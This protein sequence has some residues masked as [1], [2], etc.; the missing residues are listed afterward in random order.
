MF[1]ATAPPQLPKPRQSYMSGRMYC[2]MLSCVAQAISATGMVL[3][4]SA[5]RN[6]EANMPNTSASDGRSHDGWRKARSAASA[7]TKV[8]TLEFRPTPDAASTKRVDGLWPPATRQA[9]KSSPGLYCAALAAT[10][11]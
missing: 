8:N 1:V 7:A 10:N 4:I 6:D 11:A 5:L 2:A 9:S 3:V